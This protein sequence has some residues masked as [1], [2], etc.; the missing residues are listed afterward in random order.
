MW[1]PYNSNFS[2][3]IL[4]L[5]VCCCSVTKS[6]P[7]LYDPMDCSTP[8]FPV[9]HLSFTLSCLLEFAQTHVHWVND[10]IQPSH[11]L[12]SPSPPA[13]SLYQHQGLF[14]RVDSSHQVAKVL[15]LQLQH[16]SFQ[17]IFRL[18]SFRIDCF[19]FLVAQETLKSFH[20]HHN[21]KTSICDSPA[22]TLSTWTSMDL[23]LA[24]HLC[25][26]QP[27]ISTNFLFLRGD[28]YELL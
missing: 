6:C 5:C 11:P 27:Y 28:F 7:T 14:Q 18:I 16:Q 12:S 10:A 23:T 21:L 15:E 24:S 19:D 1:P 26:H 3:T 8:G 9:L 17:W 20:K 13:F 25:L 2:A 4:Q 22:V